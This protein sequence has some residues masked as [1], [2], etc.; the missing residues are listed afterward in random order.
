MDDAAEGC[1]LAECLSGRE[2]AGVYTSAHQHTAV[3][4]EGY[5]TVTRLPQL[6][7]KSGDTALHVGVGFAPGGRLVALLRH[8]G[9]RARPVLVLDPA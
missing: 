5:S 6:V 3:G 7:K 2:L 8:Q 9:P 4:K 1:E